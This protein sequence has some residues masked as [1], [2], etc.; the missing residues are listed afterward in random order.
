HFETD[1]IKYLFLLQLR[2]ALRHVRNLRGSLTRCSVF[3]DQ[4]FIFSCF[5]SP[6]HLSGDLINITY[7]RDLSQHF[8]KLFFNFISALFSQK[9]SRA[10]R[11]E[12]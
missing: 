10:L 8:F 2:S 1:E 6:P 4:T 7:I 11:A 9:N 5:V 12:N 3:K